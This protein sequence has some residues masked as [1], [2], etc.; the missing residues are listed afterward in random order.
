AAGRD[1]TNDGE[2]HEAR[3][4][5][6]GPRN[7]IRRVPVPPVLVAMI[8]EHV[9]LYGTAPDGRLFQTYRGGIYLPSTLWH[10]LQKARKRAFTASQ[11]ASPLASKPY[12][13]R[14][15]GVSWRLNAGAPPPQVAEW[16]GHTVEVLHRIY[17]HCIDGD[18][19]RWFGAMEDALGRD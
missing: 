11:V 10:V 17:T 14:H 13:F 7:A 12:D 18:D 2:V 3:A 1:W 8:R 4:P 19:D 6:G 15:A 9:E 16:A 5:K